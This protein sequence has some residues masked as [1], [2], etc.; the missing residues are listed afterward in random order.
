MGKMYEDFIS[1]FIILCYQYFINL[2]LNFNYSLIRNFINIRY[3]ILLGF[4][5]PIL[6]WGF[7]PINSRY[8]NCDIQLQINNIDDCQGCGRCVR[9]VV[10]LV[11]SHSLL[12]SSLTL[13]CATSQSSLKKCIE[14][15]CDI[16]ENLF[17][18]EDQ[19]YIK[20]IASANLI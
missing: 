8:L 11:F 9:V 19:K 13:Q 1:Y 12:F 7:Q 3:P 20:Y 6:T 2:L 17:T 4:Q 15:Y 16:K 5:F 14:T 18:S 10:A